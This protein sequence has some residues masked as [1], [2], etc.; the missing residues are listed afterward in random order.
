MLLA[1][2]KH[3]QNTE[4]EEMLLKGSSQAEEPFDN[5]CFDSKEQET[6]NSS[7][8]KFTRR[9]RASKS[10]DINTTE[11]LAIRILKRSELYRCR[12]LYPCSHHHVEYAGIGRYHRRAEAHAGAV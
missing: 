3:D 4:G 7:F 5:D 10:L 9:A 8:F 11:Q 6:E 12:S 2:M 1:V